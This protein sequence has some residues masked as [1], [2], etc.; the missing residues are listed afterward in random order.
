M[1]NL[2]CNTLYCI[3]EKEAW[4]VEFE[5]QYSGMYCNRG[6][7]VGQETVLQ[8][9]VAIGRVGPGWAGPTVGRAKTGPGQNWPCFFWPKF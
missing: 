2:Y 3:V 9:E 5:L 4:R 1:E 7:W 6:G 8:L